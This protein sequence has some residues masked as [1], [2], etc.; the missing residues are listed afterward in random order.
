LLVSWPSLLHNRTRVYLFRQVDYAI[1]C[2]VY[3]TRTRYRLATKGEI[4]KETS[5]PD[6]FVAKILQQ[7]VR[8]GLVSS[9]RGVHGGFVLARDPANLSL[10]DV[11]EITQA[12]VAPRPCVLDPRACPFRDT[13]PVHPVWVKIH[14]ATEREMRKVSFASLARQAARLRRTRPPR[15]HGARKVGPGRQAL[16]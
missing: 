7:L 11:I 15:P 1:R 14:R 2:L 6:L 5:A 8:A 13:C 16:G 12:R 9:T 10:L 3:L 4:A